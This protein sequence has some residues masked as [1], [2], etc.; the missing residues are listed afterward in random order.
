MG[1]TTAGPRAWTVD[2]VPEHQLEGAARQVQH[3]LGVDCLDAL[4]YGLPALLE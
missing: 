4:D 1:N 2:E 3:E